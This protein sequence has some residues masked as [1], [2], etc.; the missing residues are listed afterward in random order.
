MIIIRRL[1]PEL[2]KELKKPIG[3]LIRGSF[4]ETMRKLK[5]MVREEKPPKIISVGDRVSKNLVENG[6]LP[7]L[8]IVD[9]R[10]MRRRILP[11]TL[12][13]DETY[14]VRNPPGTITN[15]AFVEIQKSLKQNRRVKI[16][17]DGE[18]DLLALAAVLY[19]PENSFVVYGQP[20]EGIV[21]VRVTGEKKAKVAEILKSMKNVSKS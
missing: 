4:S 9:N 17:V 16:V 3:I 19:A 13:A 7:H 8:S 20:R 6:V 10:V 2:R 18:E 11:I 21:V 12:T 15:E 14:Y 1:T 5:N